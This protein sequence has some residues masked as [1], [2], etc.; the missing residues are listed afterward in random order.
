MAKKRYMQAINE[1]L[2]EEMERDPKTIL[3][4]EDVEISMFGDTAGI[5]DRF[6][7]DRIRNTPICEA[8]L[9]GMA[10]GAAASGYR[11]ILHM[12]FAN[13]IYSY[14]FV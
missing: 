2:I 7:P 8:T 9:T 6:G 11:V 3:Y 4:G 5:L 12:M 13:F 1:A 10:V 14:N